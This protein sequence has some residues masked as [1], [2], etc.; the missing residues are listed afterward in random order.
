RARSVNRSNI[1]APS[2]AVPPSHLAVDQTR[3]DGAVHLLYRRGTTVPA[4]APRRRRCQTRR[5]PDSYPENRLLTR[6]TSATGRLETV[7]PLHE[8]YAQS[9]I[10]PARRAGGPELDH[11]G[12]DGVSGPPRRCTDR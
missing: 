7:F 4:G 9:E 10:G 6:R 5:Q 3:S 1:P 11:G 12:G 2:C 8:Q